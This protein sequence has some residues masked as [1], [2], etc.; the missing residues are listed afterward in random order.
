LAWLTRA[1]KRGNCASGECAL[2][3]VF[4]D[5]DGWQFAAPKL[6]PAEKERLAVVYFT[7]GS[8]SNN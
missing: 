4:N 5:S 7:N 2:S 3:Q 1:A 6:S 8:S